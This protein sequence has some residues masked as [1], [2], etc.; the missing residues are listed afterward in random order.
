MEKEQGEEAPSTF[1]VALLAFASS[2]GPFATNGIV[3]SFVS[4]TDVL[5]VSMTQMQTALTLYLLAFAVGSLIVGAISDTYG[6]CRVL[7]LGMLFFSVATIFA[8]YSTSLTELNFWRVVQG[9][10]ASVGQVITQAMVRDRWGGMTATKVMSLI[11]MLFALSPAFAPVIGGWIV[12]SFGWQAVFW[13]LFL[14]A[15]SI[16]IIAAFALKESLPKEKRKPLN[17]RMLVLNYGNCF[18][19][20]AFVCGVLSHSMCSMGALLVVAGGA[21][22]VV[23]V[24]G[25]S[26]DGFAWMSF[27]VV[28]IAFVGSWLAPWFVRCFGRKTAVCSILCLTVVLE[29]CLVAVYSMGYQSY[30]LI[31][32]APSIIQFFTAIARPPVM[33]MNLDYMP[34]RKGMAASIQQSFFTAGFA[35]ASSVL[36][37]LCIGSAAKYALAMAFSALMA[38]VFWAMSMHYRREVFPKESN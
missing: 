16:G 35:L 13:F 26:V 25:F 34:D 6:R 17:L 19:H 10:S 24:M 33:V 12:V 32:L 20:K 15:M 27:P 1:Q 9:F 5:N 3:P 31:I 37:P 28:T 8:T 14:Y 11:G 29:L 23:R 30:V 38:A 7:A 22:F 21:D 4:L 36:V 18:T 2:L